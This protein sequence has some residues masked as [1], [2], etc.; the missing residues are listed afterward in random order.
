MGVRD[1][2]DQQLYYI[3]ST[4]IKYTLLKKGR[5]EDN[6]RLRNTFKMLKI[7]LSNC[8]TQF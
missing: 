6:V 1:L 5:L 3:D 4:V 2:I 8:I 7:I